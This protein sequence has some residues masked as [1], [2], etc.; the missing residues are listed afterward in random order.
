MQRKYIKK[1]KNSFKYKKGEENIANEDFYTQV[2]ETKG[3]KTYHY[4]L[5]KN[6][7]S[8]QLI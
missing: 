7:E 1:L 3:K 6:D 4:G 8:D 2:S 5:G